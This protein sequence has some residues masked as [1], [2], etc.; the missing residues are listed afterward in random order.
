[1][2]VVKRLISMGMVVT[3][4][5]SLIVGCG[6]DEK[7][8]GTTGEP[9]TIRFF[10]SLGEAEPGYKPV[11]EIVEK[12]EKDNPDI[13]VELEVQSSSQYHEKLVSEIASDTLAN[14]FMHWGGA[15]MYEAVASG[16]V[17]D[18]TER[19]DAEPEF[20]AH[21]SDVTLNA[22]NLRYED[23]EGMW[24][25]PLSNVSAGFYY[26]KAL[27]EKAGIANPPA[28]WEELL[29]C[30][31]KLKA[32]DII[33][34][35]MG[36]KDGWRVEHLYSAIFFKMNGVEAAKKLGD[37]SLKYSSKEAVAPW[38]EISKLV[39]MEAFGPEPASVDF[40]TEQSMVSTG[41][42]AINFSLSSFVEMYAGEECEVGDDIG[43]FE[44]PPF[45]GK[46]EFAKNNFGGG[47]VA[48]GIAANATDAQIDASWKLCEALCGVEGQTVIANSN[49]LLVANQDVE[50]DPAKVNRLTDD[51]A[52]VINN[53][54]AATIAATNWDKVATMLTKSRDVASA[55]VNKQL[56]PEQAGAELDAEVEMYG[57]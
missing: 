32:A 51:F 54:D 9:V 21:F 40:A 28:T 35:A 39:D 2:S 33:P 29:D 27:F 53:A 57:E 13:K 1:M 6:K 17:L 48:L 15:E 4:M 16:K 36:A 31:E 14:V 41:K 12:F 30:V 19:L 8:K 38:E 11:L 3:M 42:A 46:E 37:R 45:E 7:D 55:L 5:A 44:M 34:W 20:K 10:S 47:D 49:A 52:N 56:T 50:V 18:V 25:M 22:S 23:M 24:G 43:F 26:N